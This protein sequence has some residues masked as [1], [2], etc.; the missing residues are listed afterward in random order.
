MTRFKQ[1]TALNPDFVLKK[2][3][4]FFSEDHIEN[5]ITTQTIQRNHTVEAT[6]VAREDLIFAGNEII[7]QGFADCTISM[8]KDD[9]S[10]LNQGDVIANISGNI[11]TI[12]KKE[13]VVLN[14]IQRLCGIASKV[15]QLCQ[16]TRK[17][18]IELLDTRKTTP[19]LRMFEKFAV[20]IG[21][22]V[23]HRFSLEDAVMIKDNH[24]VGSPDIIQTVAK[25]KHDNP[26]K[27][28][29]LE[30]DTKDQ[31]KF[32]LE[33]EATSL[34]LDNF[35]SH[36]LP[37]V[38]QNIRSHNKGEK[39]YIELSGGITENTLSDFCI[40]GVNGISMGALTHNI[41]S[42]DIGLDIK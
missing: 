32:A 22:G 4:E 36:S 30:I 17:Y 41:K 20:A 24:L 28:I 42:K 19:G 35:Q 10:K 7:K 33:S 3:D 8:I 37:N 16:K 6:F 25:A 23:N 26:G 31:L 14:L 18:N 11:N 29:Q 39:M 13:R 12:L 34:L 1:H 9:G 40:Q 5:D 38:I 2:L 27:D 15:N 21:G